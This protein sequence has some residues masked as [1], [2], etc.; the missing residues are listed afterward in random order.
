M[1][2]AQH[3]DVVQTLTPNRTDH[4]FSVRVLPGRLRRSRY[5][6]YMERPHL[7]LK[8][9]PVNR[10]AIFPAKTSI[11]GPRNADQHRSSEA[12]GGAALHYRHDRNGIAGSHGY[13]LV[14]SG[15]RVRSTASILKVVSYYDSR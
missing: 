14:A 13:P 11:A 8:H 3:D 15:T 12:G 6:C 5:L 4:T 2:L 7:P 9:F 1:A 10:V